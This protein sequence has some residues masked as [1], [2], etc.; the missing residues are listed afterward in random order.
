[1]PIKYKIRRKT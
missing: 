1:V